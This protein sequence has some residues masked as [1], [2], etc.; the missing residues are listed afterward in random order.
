MHYQ[1]VSYITDFVS[2]VDFVSLYNQV[3]LIIINFNDHI[4]PRVLMQD[5]Y[6]KFYP[7]LHTPLRPSLPLNSLNV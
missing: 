5:I 4:V 2:F 6:R 3:G 7:Q 1:S